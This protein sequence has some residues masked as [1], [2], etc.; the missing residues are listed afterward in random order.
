MNVDLKENKGTIKLYNGF[1]M[2]VIGLGTWRLSGEN[3]KESIKFALKEGYRHIDT[4]TLY[5]NEEI[6]GQAIKESGIPR[7][8]IFVTT[9]LANT[10]HKN[11]PEALETS[12]KKLQ[13]DYVDLYLIHWPISLDPKTKIRYVDWNYIDTYKVMQTFLKTSKVKSIGVSN[14]TVEDLKKLMSHE[15]IYIVPV[16]NQI[17]A[18][19]LLVQTELY[20]YMKEKKI[21][22]VAYS[23]LGSSNSPLLSNPDVIQ[24][25]K[26]NNIEPA[27]LLVSWG[28]QRDSVVLVKSASESR[29]ISNFKTIKLSDE[30]FKALNNLSQKYGVVRTCSYS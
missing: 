19:P 2:P 1:T 29:I 26:K 3:A 18:H 11:A 20:D 27:Q 10:D 23:P 15:D 17:E 24:I 8:E 28:I 30:D 4:A 5:N 12:L 7:S 9:K 14:F 21:Q 22:I 13:L 16:V 25:A 6:V